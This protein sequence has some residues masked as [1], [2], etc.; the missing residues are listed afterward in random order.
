MVNYL[1]RGLFDML[2]LSLAQEQHPQVL[3][4]FP[5]KTPCIDILVGLHEMYVYA[6]LLA[7]YFFL[8]KLIQRESRLHSRWLQRFK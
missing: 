4:P 1:Q 8:F 6:K 7:S 3:R 2:L 5:F